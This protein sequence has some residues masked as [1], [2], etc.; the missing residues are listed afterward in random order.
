MKEK[1]TPPREVNLLELV[2]VRNME[3]ETGRG[4]RV[5]LLQPKFRNAFLARHLLPLMRNPH[6]RVKLDEIGSFFWENCDG[7]RTIKEIAELQRQKFGEAVEPLYDRMSLFLQTLQ[8]SR[9]IS[10]KNQNP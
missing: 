3:W 5:V 2:P 10:F 9:F 8:R 1:K 4:K 6:Y 7:I